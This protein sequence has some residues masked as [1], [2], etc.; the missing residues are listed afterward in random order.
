MTDLITRRREA[1]ELT[2]NLFWEVAEHLN[3]EAD[4]RLR[5]LTAARA[6]ESAAVALAERVLGIVRMKWVFQDALDAWQ[7]KDGV[8]AFV[9]Q[10]VAAILLAKEDRE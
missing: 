2:F 4:G 1:K 9:L 5:Q 10:F 8:P 6:W 3:V 7:P